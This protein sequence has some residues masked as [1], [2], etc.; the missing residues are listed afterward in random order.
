MSNQYPNPVP[1]SVPSNGKKKRRDP[2]KPKSGLLKRTLLLTGVGVVGII[3]GSAATG[4]APEPEVVVEEK[5]VEK[6]VPVEKIVE[7]EVEVVTEKTP[8]SCIDALDLAE[9]INQINVQV[10][11]LSASSFDAV[12]SFDY[13]KVNSNS[14]KVSSLTPKLTELVSD[15]NAKSGVCRIN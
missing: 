14:S 6:E 8:A 13:A 2:N 9:E 12:S 4:G 3:I 11:E 1:A 5:V 15:Y 10:H 7:K